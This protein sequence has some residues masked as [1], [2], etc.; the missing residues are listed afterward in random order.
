MVVVANENNKLIFT[1][2]V[3]GYRVC[4]GYKKLN[5]AIDQILDKFTG[6]DYHC[7]F[8]GYSYYKQ[9][10]IALEDQEKTIRLL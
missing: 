8:D 10:A 6:N 3:I 1:R 9:I 2:T 4:M 7:L 5:K